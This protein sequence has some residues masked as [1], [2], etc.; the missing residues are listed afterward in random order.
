LAGYIVEKVR[1]WVWCAHTCMHYGRTDL[2]LTLLCDIVGQMGSQQ[3]RHNG[4]LP[5]KSS[6]TAQQHG[7]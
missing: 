2:C 5:P 1:R 3:L 4:A 7:C 6:E